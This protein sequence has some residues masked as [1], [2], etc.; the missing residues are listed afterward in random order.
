MKNPSKGAKERQ[1]SEEMITFNADDVCQSPAYLA[2]LSID[3]VAELSPEQM[4][5]RRKEHGG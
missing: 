4:S 3:E 1:L 2:G 5:K